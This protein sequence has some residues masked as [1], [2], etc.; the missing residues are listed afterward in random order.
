[1][2]NGMRWTVVALAALVGLGTT[3]AASAQDLA[4]FDYENLSF[5]GF[6]PEWGYL[7]PTRVEATHSYGVRFDLGYL[8][9]GVRIVPSVMYWSSPLKASEV[10]ELE[11]SVEQLI[12]QQIDGP[13]PSVNLGTIEWTDVAVGLDAHVVWRVPFGIL[14]YAGLGGAIHVLNGKGAAINGTFVEDLLDSLE[15]GMNLHLG[16][17]YLLSDRLRFSSQGRYEVLG[18]LQYFQV[19]AGLQFMVGASHPGEVGGS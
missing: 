10:R 18:D 2:R 19:R 13:S 17:E 1:M 3:Q 16:A 7:V 14:T 9:P 11:A 5:R 12:D 15:P 8:G 4:D 6:G